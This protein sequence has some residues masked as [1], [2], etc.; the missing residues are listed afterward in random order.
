MYTLLV[1]L[2]L[3]LYPINVKTVKPIGLK[4]FCVTSR[5]PREGLWV[6]KF[7]KICLHPNSIFLIL[8]INEFFFIKSGKFLFV[9]VLHCYTKRTLFTMEMEDGRKVP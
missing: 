3:S 2:S 4:F 8:K 9:F 7:S 5:D 6:I 1:C